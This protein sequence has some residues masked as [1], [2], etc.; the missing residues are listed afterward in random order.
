MSDRSTEIEALKAAAAALVDLKA[1]SKGRNVFKR[2]MHDAIV[3]RKTSIMLGHPDISAIG[4]YQK[5]LKELWDE[6]DQ[7]AWEEKAANE[8]KDIFE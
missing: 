4:A 8:G 7:E 6:A 3:S 1:F 5:G 2:E